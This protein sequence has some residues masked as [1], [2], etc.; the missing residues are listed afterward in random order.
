MRGQ[1]QYNIYCAVCHGYSGEGNGLANNRAVA[2]STSGESAWTEAKSL[3]DPTVIDQPEDRW[4][5]VL[6]LKALQK[7]RKDA[8]SKA[9]D[10]DSD[11]D[12]KD[13]DKQR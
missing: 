4:A 2:L 7:T 11:S 13:S 5:I 3:Y 8:L 12:K 9:T 1:R 10:A 6:Y